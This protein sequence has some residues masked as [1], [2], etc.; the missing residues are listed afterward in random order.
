[1]HVVEDCLVDPV[2]PRFG[3]E[4]GQT[5][6]LWTHHKERAIR[7]YLRT[8]DDAPNTDTGCVRLTNPHLLPEDSL[9]TKMVVGVHMTD[10][11]HP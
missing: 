8:L 6:R 1:M 11:D 10:V 7:P 5:N 3:L 4:Q 2:L 9:K